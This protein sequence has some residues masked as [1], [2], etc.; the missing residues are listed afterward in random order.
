MQLIAYVLPFA[1]EEM[2][3]LETV[4]SESEAIRAY[5]MRLRTG[6]GISQDSLADDIGMPRRTYI[7][8]ETGE[9]KDIKAPALIR[10]IKVLGGAFTHLGLLD[11]APEERG[12]QIADEWLHL[13]PEQREQAER[14]QSKFERVIALADDDPARLEQ[15]IERIRSDARSD[16]AVLDVIVAYLD[17]R[18]S[19]RS[20]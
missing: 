8:W 14:I 12:R 3:I 19:S 15:V 17:G 1:G 10:A 5:I 6:Q 9:T 2:F 7:A 20:G 11:D 16:P 18:R 4:V 13:T